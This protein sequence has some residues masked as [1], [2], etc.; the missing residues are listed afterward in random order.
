MYNLPRC[1][2]D[3]WLSGRVSTVDTRQI[4]AFFVVIIRNFLGVCEVFPLNIYVGTILMFDFEL[5][6]T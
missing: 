2:Q 3:T 6:K 1:H 5:Y 4:V